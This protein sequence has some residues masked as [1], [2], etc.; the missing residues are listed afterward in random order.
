MYVLEGSTL[1]GKIILRTVRSK[2]VSTNELH[3]LDPYG[4][5][6]SALWRVFLR[7]LERE[8]TPDP[9]AM[10]ECVSGATKAFVFAAACLH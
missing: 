5:D 3:F 4:K 10:K 1:G 7:V 2:G 6:A 8:T 9:A